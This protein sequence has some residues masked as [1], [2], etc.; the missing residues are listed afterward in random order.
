MALLD[1]GSQIIPLHGYTPIL[2][3][4]DEDAALYR[5]TVD[6]PGNRVT[7]CTM[8]TDA[9]AAIFGVLTATLQCRT[10]SGRYG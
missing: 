6:I 5:W 1:G 7:R 10:M 4:C 9:K 3:R 2:N 8:M